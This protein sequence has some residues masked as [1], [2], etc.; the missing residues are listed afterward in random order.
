MITDTVSLLALGD[1]YTI[2]ESVDPALS[3]PV[4]LAREL[5]IEGLAVG[6]PVIIARTGWTTDEL[7][8][9]I[10]KARLTGPFEFVS[11]LI[12]V[13]DQYRG[14][15]LEVYRVEFRDLLLQAIAFTGG[16]P[17][18]VLVLSIPDWGVTPFAGGMDRERIG[19]EI[20]TF[21]RVNR[22]E[23]ETAGARYLNVTGI[24]RGV[25]SDPSLLAGDGLH[26][27]GVMYS[28][29]VQAALP[30]AKEIVREMER[31]KEVVRERERGPA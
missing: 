24:S 15:G 25:P 30:I 31:G 16:N 19:R 26:P 1:S 27:S 20:D 4:Q 14:R 21:N 17:R 29:W 12:G 11:L 2:G 22:E 3:W 13:N 5:R 18:S 9:G 6:E 28:R 10:E 8:G 7:A 23:S